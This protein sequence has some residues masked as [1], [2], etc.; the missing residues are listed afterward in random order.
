M[1][2]P[3]TSSLLL[4]SVAL[5]A[6]LSGCK[7][8]AAL[9]KSEVIG[10]GSKSP[11]DVPSASLPAAAGNSSES[12]PIGSGVING[13]VA[14]SGPAPAKIKIDTSMDPACEMGSSAPVYTEQYAVAN[15]KLANVYVYVKDGPPAALQ[16]GPISM[17][18]VVLDQKGCQYQPHVIALM[19]GGYV[20]FRN[21]DITMH[22]IH[23]MPTQVGNETIDISQGPKG[24]PVRKQFARPE[25]MI[26]VRCNNHPWMN[27]FINV[28]STPYFAVTDANGHFSLAG[29]PAGSYTIAAVHEKLGEKDIQVTVPA[30]GTAKADFSFGMK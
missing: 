25:L 28:S 26:P 3:K 2:M 24:A 15:G 7:P 6:S 19:Q 9:Q 22:N 20:E 17:Q 13:T 10:K 16:A 29:L 18:P 30:T 5:A 23:T 21:S 14:F 1:N 12:A 8:D 4:L 11:T 27:A